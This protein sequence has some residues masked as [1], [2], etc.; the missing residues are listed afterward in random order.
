MSSTYIKNHYLIR[1]EL[2]NKYVPK[3]CYCLPQIKRV[4]LLFFMRSV[5]DFNS[6]ASKSNFYGFIHLLY[7]LFG[8]VP[9]LCKKKNPVDKF[10]KESYCLKLVF[11]ET[12]VIYSYLFSFFVQSCVFSTKNAIFLKNTVIFNCLDNKFG[13][14]L[15]DSD[16][17]SRVSVEFFIPNL[18]LFENKVLVLKNLHPFKNIL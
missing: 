3:S 17:V 16:V 15:F 14:S 5:D 2:L 10:S 7:N 13:T 1:C 9:L 4:K 12:D 8:T 6:T 11:T 18:H